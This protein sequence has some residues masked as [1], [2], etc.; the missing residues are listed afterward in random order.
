MLTNLKDMNEVAAGVIGS[1]IVLA[2][3]PSIC[4]RYAQY[5]LRRSKAIACS[6]LDEF[7]KIANT[8]TQ[9]G[10]P[11]ELKRLMGEL[12]GIMDEL[13]F[14]ENATADPN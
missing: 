9:G 6:R 4:E 10:T 14:L 2:S 1:L 11:V 12:Q 13:Q 3:I 7:Q 8:Y 5:E